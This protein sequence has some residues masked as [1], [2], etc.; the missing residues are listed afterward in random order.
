MNDFIQ[1]AAG[2]YGYLIVVAVMMIGLY[3]M[4][5]YGNL[6]K[7]LIGLGVFQS[8]VFVLFILLAAVGGAMPPILG[9]AGGVYANPLPHVLIL[10]AIVVSIATTALGLALAV[11]VND[12]WGTL[13]EEEIP[14]LRNEL[15]D[16]SGDEPG[17]EPR[18]EHD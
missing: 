7:K 15:G 1:A 6:I 14:P 11:R 12:A 5:A 17:S 13:E 2:H 9:E 4:I 10:T 18:G 8:A 16:K 3:I